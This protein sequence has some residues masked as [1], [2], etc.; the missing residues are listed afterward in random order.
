MLLNR[1]LIRTLSILVAIFMIVSMVT[2][3][4]VPLFS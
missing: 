2:F 1:T 3:L 4:L